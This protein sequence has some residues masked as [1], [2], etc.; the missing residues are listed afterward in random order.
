MKYGTAAAFRR[1]LEQR[2]KD[3]AAGVPAKIP[4]NRKRIV[5]DRLLARLA[6]TSPRDWAVKGGFALDL[7]LADRAR[8]TQDIDLAWSEY[9]DELIDALLDAVAHDV[10]DFFAFDIERTDDPADRLG[11]THRF[12]VRASLAGRQFETFLLDIGT[13]DAA[14]GSVEVIAGPALLD[15]AGIE[16]IAIPLLP[17]ATQVA[18]KLHAYTRVYEGGRESTRP[19]DL[20]DLVLT[21]LFFELDAAALRTAIDE[22]FTHRATHPAPATLP[23]PPQAWAIPYRRLAQEVEIRPDLATGYALA[24][25]LLDPIL[26]TRVAAGRW[27]PG[28]QRWTSPTAFS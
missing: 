20:I 27:E 5:F 24:A 4:R 10:G 28:V 19:K 3:E 6:V 11:G 18:E 1:A 7:R 26:S 23:A 8:T 17:L 25:G 12:R 13:Q 15:F 9:A 22:V 21:A 14:I 16:P 2:L